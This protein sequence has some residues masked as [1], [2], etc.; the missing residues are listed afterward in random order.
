MKRYAKY[1]KYSNLLLYLM[2]KI[3]NH[4]DSTFND[5]PKNMNL[6]K[7]WKLSYINVH[8]P[9]VA[10]LGSIGNDMCLRNDLSCHGVNLPS[11]KLGT[12]SSRTRPST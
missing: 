11:R 5:I 10:I 9:F 2:G 3:I 1:P 8:V 6:H 7:N 12:L 4:R